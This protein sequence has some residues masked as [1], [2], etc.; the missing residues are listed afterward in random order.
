MTCTDKR[1][2]FPFKTI[3]SVIFL[4]ALFALICPE[5]L[6]AQ[7][8]AGDSAPPDVA[9]ENWVPLSELDDTLRDSVPEACCG[10]YLNPEL[11]PPITDGSLLIEAASGRFDGNTQEALITG[12]IDIRFADIW[13]QAEQGIYDKLAGI[14]ELSGNIRLRQAGLSIG[15]TSATVNTLSASSQLQNTSYVLHELAARGNAELLSFNNADKRLLITQGSYTVCEPGDDTWLLVG[16]QI[17]LD[18]NTGRGT[19]RSIV[20]RVKNIPVFY[21]PY[22]S[23]PINDERSSGL[24]YPSVGSTREGGFDYAQPYYF[25]LA[26]NYDAT[27]TP[28]LMSER[29]LMMSLEGRHLGS[30]SSNELQL[31]YLHDDA[32]YDTATAG[33]PGSE[34]PPQARRWQLNYLGSAAFTRQWSARADFSAISDFDYYQDFGNTGLT[35]T[36]RSYLYRHGE[37]DYHGQDLQLKASLQSFQQIDPSLSDLS[38]PYASLPRINLNYLGD[39]NNGPAY[40]LQAEYV[41]FD[42]QLNEALLTPAQIDNGLLVTG[43]RFSLQPRLS[44]RWQSPGAYLAPELGYDYTAYQLEQQALGSPD[45]M[46][47]GIPG[48]E[49][50]AGLIF[51]RPLTFRDQAFTQTLEPRLYYL[52]RGYD[53]QDT[54]P[55]FDTANLSSGYRQLF[56]DNRFSGRDRIGDANQL[57]LALS[58]RFLDSDGLEKVRLSLG[59]ILYFE[60]RR[61][62]LMPAASTQ[63]QSSSTFASEF[64][65]QLNENWRL[66]LFQEWDPHDRQFDSG[67]FQFRYQSDI[68]QVLN[69]SYRY[70]DSVNIPGI[71]KQTDISALWPVSDSIGLIGRWNYDHTNKRNLEAIVGL[72]YSSCCWDLRLIARRWVDNTD[73]S[74]NFVREN[75]GFFLQFELEGLGNILGNSIES[76]LGDSI[77][78][79]KTYVENN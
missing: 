58:S 69:F 11:P 51:E 16:N 18:Q 34:S 13:L 53:N 43:Q 79:F 8:L 72:E 25:N 57:T 21:T 78:G 45:R 23:F 62:S 3:H 12:S 20:L 56:R 55:L 2:L 73:L 66:A 33:L 22:L 4:A 65:Y 54:I 47:R 36:T 48:A 64:S 24:L 68:N 9:T 5:L 28:R 30:S 74:G 35:D 63:Q 50:D 27:L 39:F 46:D 6:F 76:L 26:P 14:V 7:D 41:Y 38:K 67:S 77:S 75:N 19:G 59:Q 29:G 37:L 60:D 44:W 52:Y 49:L 40:A 71:I 15:A 32:Q 1:H 70:R 31:S 10:L 42:R 61:V 17:E